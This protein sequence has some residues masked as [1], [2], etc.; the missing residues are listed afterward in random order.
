MSS[1]LSHLERPVSKAAF[2]AHRLASRIG[3]PAS[4]IMPLRDQVHGRF[5]H[6]DMTLLLRP[7][8][9]DAWTAHPGHEPETHRHIAES[10]TPEAGYLF[11][12]GAFCGSFSLRHRKQ[13][14][15]IV[16][17]EASSENYAALSR[18]IAQNDGNVTAVN[19]AVADTPGTLRLYLN[20]S[21]T[22]SLIGD[23]GYEEV[24]ATTLDESWDQA[25]RPKVA[26]IKI[27]VE[28]AE[29]GVIRGATE[30]LKTFPD[31]IAEANDEAAAEELRSLMQARGYTQRR[32]LDDRNLLFGH[33][34]A[35]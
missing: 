32:V 28:G 26:L 34:S 29:P 22:H 35:A 17:F 5:V 15:G 7:G 30:L 14:E 6:P 27:D 33:A 1:F 18:N 4:A 31:L 24:R 20:T 13:F 25:G 19:A 2:V 21:D 11:D 3:L 9:W 10:Y 12:V 23:G 16:A 8:S